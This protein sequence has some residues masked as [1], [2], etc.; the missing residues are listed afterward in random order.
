MHQKEIRQ[1]SILFASRTMTA[2]HGRLNSTLVVAGGATGTPLSEPVLN[3]S[4]SLSSP[5][6]EAFLNYFSVSC[7]I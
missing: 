3:Q 7:A 5:G 4:S 6:Y 2:H 1:N